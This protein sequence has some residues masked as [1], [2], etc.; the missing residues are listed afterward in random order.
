MLHLISDAD[1]HG[2]IV[3]G[4]RGRKPHIDLVRVQEVELR[5]AKDDVILEWAASQNRIVITQD[6]STMIAAARNRITAGLPM[7]GL[8]VL[9]QRTTIRQAI[10]ALLLVDGC[11][12]QHEWQ[13]RIEFLPL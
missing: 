11:S 7:P 8:F 2:H 9:R 13:N 1:V 3:R 5:T 10:D 12:E 4:L 6:H